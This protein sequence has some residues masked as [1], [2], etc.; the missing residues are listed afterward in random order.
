MVSDLEPFDVASVLGMGCRCAGD[1]K[2]RQRKMGQEA[3][4]CL[5]RTT[6]LQSNGLL[7]RELRDVDM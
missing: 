5:Y 4:S 2:R 1:D 3:A 7:V 6:R